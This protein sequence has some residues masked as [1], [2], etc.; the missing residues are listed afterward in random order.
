MRIGE[1]LRASRNK[2]N[3]TLKELSTKSGL[4]ISYL[5]DI[6]RSRAM[7]SLKT[8]QKIANV[9]KLALHNLLYNVT[10]RIENET[11]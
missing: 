8:C 11:N 4:S 3:L 2:R 9:Y 6:E 10:I 5:S 1:K 7:P